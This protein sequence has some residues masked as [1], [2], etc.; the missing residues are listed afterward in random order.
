MSALLSVRDLAVHLGDAPLV[1]GISFDLSA[2]EVL[3]IVGESGSGK[4]MTAKALMGLLPPKAR[5]HGTAMFDGTNLVSQEAA[6][7]RGTGIG[8]IFQ[9]PMTALTPVLTIGLQLTE[10]LLSH[11]ICDAVE[12]KRRAKAMLD[13]V[14]IPEPD[15]QMRQYP[16]ELS[17]GM[18]QRVVIA[19]MMLLDPRVLIADEPTTALDVTV[20]AQIL[21]L[22]R[23]IVTDAQIGLILITH[24]MGVVAEMADTV[25]VMKSGRTQEYGPAAQVFAQPESVYTQTLLDAVPRIDSISERERGATDILLQAHDIT[26]TFKKRTALFSGHDKHTALDDVSLDINRG[27]TLALVGESGS[28]KT[29]LGRVIAR[30]TEPD[31][32]QV[33]LNGS[34][35]M[36][37]SGRDLQAR[38]REVQMVFQDPYASLDP[39]QTIGKTI[40][41]PLIIHQNLSKQD[42]NNQ[43]AGLLEKVGLD[44]D[45]ALRYPH[46]FSG[47]QRQRI[48]IA[49]AIAAN[50]SL[51][52]ADEPTSALDVSIQAR[53][54][55]LLDTLRRS[56]NLTL[57]FISHDL[58]V[59]RQI[60]DRVAVMRSGRILEL[61]PAASLFAEPKHP[62]TRA[63]L[64]VAPVPDPSRKRG[65]RPAI[66][67]DYPAGPLCEVAP[68]HWVAI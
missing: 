4:S 42:R 46:E 11:G 12:A 41:E 17:G 9:E 30:L 56:E 10:A 35:L 53:V 33:L 8:L 68:S 23:Q 66:I 7:P 16:H 63:L 45:M 22:L 49:R 52:V 14:G 38:R 43:V 60:A 67:G 54:L 15:V 19:M 3:S 57:L 61:G 51:V 13:R 1:D 28:G 2:G 26:K 24:D 31:T 48:A 44:A 50:P 34:D 29:T 65:K 32:G 25:L 5:A 58:A 40:V 37:L 36:T 47:G 64:D 55:D 62:Y 27:E 20:Q 59:V 6:P 39:R 21:D 18:R